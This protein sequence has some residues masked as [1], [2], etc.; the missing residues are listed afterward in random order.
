MRESKAGAFRLPV[1]CGDKKS[2]PC[3][4]SLDTFNKLVSD[5]LGTDKQ[6]LSKC[7]SG[8]QVCR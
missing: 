5:A 7:Q 6:F 4:M 8:Q 1:A 2:K 3:E